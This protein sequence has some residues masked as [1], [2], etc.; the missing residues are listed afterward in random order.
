MSNLKQLLA[1]LLR[2]IG[3]RLF[4]LIY[5]VEIKGREHYEAAGRRALIVVNHTS[6]LD[7]PL[8]VALLR[9]SRS[10]RTS[11]R[12]GGCGRGCASSTSFASIRRARSAPGR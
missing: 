6:Y 3:A 1:L 12:S 5:R 7:A 11:P 9:A 10:I 4:Q 2:R 8:L